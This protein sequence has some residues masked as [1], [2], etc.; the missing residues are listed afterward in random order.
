MTDELDDD[1]NIKRLPIRFKTPQPEER[2]LVR[3]FEV[4]ATS[5]CSHFYTQYVVDEALAEVEC[6]KC[7][8]KLN[9]MWVLTRLANEDRRYEEA[10]K[11]HQDEM[12]RLSD[13]TRTKCFHCGKMTTI[14]RR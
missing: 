7:K 14:S 10:Q 8:A 11:R 9:P 2:T 12:Q 4:G 5:P 13:R 1:G 3:P 6:Y